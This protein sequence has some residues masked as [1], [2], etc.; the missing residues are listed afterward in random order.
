VLNGEV[1]SAPSSGGSLLWVWGSM[2][3]VGGVVPRGVRVSGELREP[4]AAEKWI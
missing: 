1:T 4:R 2:Q 3:W